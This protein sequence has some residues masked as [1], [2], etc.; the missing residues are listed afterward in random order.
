MAKW[1]NKYH[2]GICPVEAECSS[3]VSN[4]KAHK[5]NKCCYGSILENCVKSETMMANKSEVYQSIKKIT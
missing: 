2:E 1:D 3:H 4:I 5:N